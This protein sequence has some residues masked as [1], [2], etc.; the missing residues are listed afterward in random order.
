MRRETWGLVG[1]DAGYGNS[2]HSSL[3]EIP[4]AVLEDNRGGTFNGNHLM[5]PDVVPG[6]LLSTADVLPGAH[7]LEDLTGEILKRYGIA[8]GPGMRGSPVL[9]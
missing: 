1:Y 5:C 4:N 9:R 7:R 8:P 3:G 6:I 2:D